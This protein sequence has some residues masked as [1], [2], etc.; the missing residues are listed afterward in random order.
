MAQ[1]IPLIRAAAMVPFVR[2]MFENGRPV[3]QRLEAAG[4]ASL[5]LQDPDQPIPVFS[6]ATLLREMAR[7]EGPDI[8]CRVVSSASI[9]ELATLGRVALGARTPREALSRIATVLP[10]HCTH[11]H[12]TLTRTSGG[13]AVRELLALPLDVETLHVSQQYI[14]A[15][16]R[17]ICDMADAQGPAPIRIEIVQ[18]PQ[19]GLGHLARWLGPNVVAA[20]TPALIVTIRDA[21]L[22]KPFPVRARDHAAALP[23]AGWHQLRG[24]GSLAGSARVIL[25]TMLGE[26][27]PTVDQLA[28]AAGTSVRTLQR[29]LGQEGTSFSALLE[30]VRRTVALQELSARGPSVGEIAAKLG[31]ARQASLTRAVRRWTGKP[32]RE[33]RPRERR[34][35][36]P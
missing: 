15:L 35:S 3:D 34:T 4:L 8:G 7:Q 5:P 10:H 19:A 1:I 22:D 27:A 6:A 20:T 30:D 23:P 24:D 9:L 33:Q 14:A 36:R 18:H 31:Y 13:T 32:P 17:T 21:V 12:I 25:T 16:I 29:R 26:G 11:E 2:W 28:A